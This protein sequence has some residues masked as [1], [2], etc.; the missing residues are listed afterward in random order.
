MT[1]PVAGSFSRMVAMTVGR[2]CS[3]LSVDVH[4]LDACGADGQ[5]RRHGLEVAVP[6]DVEVIFGA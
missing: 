1:F 6:R 3:G 2:P 5:R 4:P